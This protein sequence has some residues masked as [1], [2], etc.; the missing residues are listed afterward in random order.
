[1]LIAAAVQ[2]KVEIKSWLEIMSILHVY[3][4]MYRM[5]KRAL[6]HGTSWM[7]PQPF[8][9]QILFIEPGH[10]RDKR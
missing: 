2:L 6:M 8:L 1:M 4:L 7:G 3:G 10:G 5:K 9:K